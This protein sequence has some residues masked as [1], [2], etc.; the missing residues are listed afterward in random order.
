[1]C[2]YLWAHLAAP[3]RFPG[4]FLKVVQNREGGGAL[5]GWGRHPCLC[6][7]VQS[8]HRARSPE[9]PE[10]AVSSPIPRGG[11]GCRGSRRRP[12]RSR[13]SVALEEDLAQVE[14]PGSGQKALGSAP[15]SDA[16]IPFTPSLAPMGRTE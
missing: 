5:A 14:S 16:R 13:R 15:R 3:T 9:V 10:L 8:R 12:Q 11:F 4:D 2:G 7:W 1:M 6:V